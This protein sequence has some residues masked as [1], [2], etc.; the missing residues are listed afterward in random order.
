MAP[1][2]SATVVSFYATLDIASA[3]GFLNSIS[4]TVN[5][6]FHTSDVPGVHE[7]DTL[8]KL[9][10]FDFESFDTLAKSRSMK[11]S[12]DHQTQPYTVGNK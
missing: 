3:E 11:N 5:S 6:G 10:I 8:L 1:F 7:P 12:G 4:E 2:S 9:N